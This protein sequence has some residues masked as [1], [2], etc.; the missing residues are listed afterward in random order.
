M[1][2]GRDLYN[3]LYKNIDKSAAEDLRRTLAKRANQRLVRLE[4]ASSTITGENFSSYGAAQIAYNYIKSTNPGKNRFREKKGFSGSYSELVNE[5][6][7]LATFLESK[8]STVSGQ[9]EIEKKRVET[10]QSGKW[11]SA[12]KVGEGPQRRSIASATN[13]E[14]YDFLNSSIFQKLKA[15]GFTSEQ[16]IE[17]YDESKEKASISDEKFYTIMDDLFQN[18]MENAT[19][20]SISDIIE[21]LD[22]KPI[23]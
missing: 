9:R 13:R 8:S 17:I 1:K 15:A 23:T 12:Y 7:N 20:P 5:I 10:F 16:I 19:T 4:R 11:G 14:F 3:D 18:W 2:T 21:K 22:L 6:L